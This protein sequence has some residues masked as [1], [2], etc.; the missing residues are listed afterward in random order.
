VRQVDNADEQH[1][2]PQIGG[3]TRSGDRSIPLAYCGIAIEA[4]IPRI[5]TTRMRYRQ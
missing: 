2:N 1:P 3:F 4:P 5:E